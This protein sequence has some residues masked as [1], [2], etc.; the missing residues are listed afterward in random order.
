MASNIVIDK[1][2]N[3]IIIRLKGMRKIAAMK[4]KVSFSIKNITDVKHAGN[5][6]KA[7]FMSILDIGHLRM[8][9]AKIGNR[10]YGGSFINMNTSPHEKEFWDVDD[11]NEAIVIH[12]N[13]EPFK[14]IY[15]STKNSKGTILQF[16]KLI[17]SGE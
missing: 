2:N 3:K 17:S 6:V 1:N 4:S 5:D 15:I 13:N 9:G 7:R 12:L 10:Y 16:K 11:P 8:I 14:R